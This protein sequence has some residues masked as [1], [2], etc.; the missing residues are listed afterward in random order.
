[1]KK[2]LGLAAL[3]GVVAFVSVSYL[4]QAEPETSTV[5]TAVEKAV[6]SS[7]SAEDSAVTEAPAEGI[8]V[9]ET[10]APATEEAVAP[11]DEEAVSPEV[12]KFMQDAEECEGIIA[13]EVE[14]A[15][16]D[17][18]QEQQDVGFTGCMI[19]RKHTA[20]DVKARYFDNQPPAPAL[21][22]AAE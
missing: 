6:E 17:I 9:E 1:M 3:L 12:A 21:D 14:A 16:K 8:A 13:A 20:A 7:K 18:S 5:T 4:A 15:G 11:V 2:Y 10:A 19:D 22:K